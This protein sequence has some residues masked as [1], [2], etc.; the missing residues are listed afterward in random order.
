MSS[1]SAAATAQLSRL[2]FHRLIRQVHLW[3]GAWGAIAAVLFGASG[4]LQNHRGVLKLPQGAT[5]EVS[6][7]EV[8]VPEEARVSAPALQ[9]WLADS[10]HLQLEPQR[11]PPGRG[12]GAGRWMF[13][14]GNARTTIQAEYSPGAAIATVRTSV[15]SPLAVVERLHKGVGG[16][17]AWILLSDSFALGM[18]ALGASG[19]IMWSRGR[20]LRR[21]LVSIVVVGAVVLA[22][23]GAS[24]IA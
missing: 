7:I 13:T 24:A 9:S 22:L 6:R 21:V 12:G 14:G 3:V 11:G 23:V 4:F 8:A 10:Q 2:R 1:S 15:H 16:G 18:V 19:L 20:T 17:V 5:T